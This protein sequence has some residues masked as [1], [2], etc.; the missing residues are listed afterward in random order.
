MNTPF[1]IPTIDISQGK[2]IL[3]RKGEVVKTH[4]DPLEAIKIINVC[5][6]VHV[7]DIDSAKGTGSNLDLIEKIAGMGTIWVGGGIRTLEKARRLLKVAARV[8]VSTQLSLLK[9]LPASKTVLAVDIDD[10]YNILTNGRTKTTDTSIFDVIKEYCSFTEIMSITFHDHEG[11]ISGIPQEHLKKI[12]AFF[13]E[14]S[15]IKVVVA[16]GIAS[17]NEV[18]HL[19]SLGV[20]CQLGSA[21][22]SGKIT[23]PD[24]YISAIDNEKSNKLNKFKEL[25]IPCVIV[26]DTDRCLGL[27]YMNKEAIESS[28][29]TRKATFYSRD[30]QELWIKGMTSGNTFEV[31]TLAIN[32]DETSLLMKVKGEHFCHLN[33]KS[34]FS[35]ETIFNLKDIYKHVAKSSL[36]N[37]YTNRLVNYKGLLQMK[38]MEEAQELAFAN[39]MS[40]NISETADLL[41]FVITWLV[42]KGITIDEVEKELNSRIC[43]KNEVVQQEKTVF[44]IGVIENYV[45]L[46]EVLEIVGKQLNCKISHKLNPLQFS[47]NSEV[48]TFVPVKPKNVTEFIAKGLLDGCVCFSDSF[49]DLKDFTSIDLKYAETE[50]VV[51]RRKEVEKKNKYIVL[52]EY[53]EATYEWIERNGINA[54]V[55][56]SSG[57]T[58]AYV[59]EKIADYG[60][61]VRATGKTLEALDL[62]VEE[63]L[64][65]SFLGIFIRSEILKNI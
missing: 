55:I 21:L 2:A 36:K 10:N 4:N 31:L 27:V 32:C 8:V 23:L 56:S 9:E 35:A 41:Y 61:V 48:L 62:V 63:Q 58:E 24:L 51:C 16:G 59:K 39:S 42:S 17:V 46:K 33:R 40:D 44:A 45:N 1:F 14:F 25:L 6:L 13:N 38:L 54:K 12:L 47:S 52:S 11:L 30:R 26:E 3:V 22:W 64:R 29:L 7:V 50:V 43:V 49:R 53:E 60:V 19:N 34:C 65:K 5:P 37:G 20:S 28:V 15:P 18:K 57:K